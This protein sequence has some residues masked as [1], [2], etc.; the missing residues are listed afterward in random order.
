MPSMSWARDR[1][2]RTK[3]LASLGLLAVVATVVAA[4]GVSQIRALRAG[5]AAMNSATIQPLVALG[6]LQRDLQSWRARVTE[7]SSALAERRQEIREENLE[8]Q[9]KVE[10]RAADYLPTAADPAAVESLQQM[11]TQYAQLTEQE[12]FAAVDAGEAGQAVTVFQEKVRPLTSDLLDAYKTEADAQAAKAVTEAESAEAS[13]GS[14]IRWV[15]IVLVAGLLLA[16]A[17][18]FWVAGGI[19]R[20]LAR[21]REALCAMAR[22]D[23]TVEAKVEGRDELGQMA[24]ALAQAREGVR[25]LLVAVR[26]SATGME[27]SSRHLADAAVQVAASAAESSGQADVVANASSAVSSS[28]QTLASGSEQMGA[29]IREISENANQAAHVASQ[30]VGVADATNATVTALGESSRQIG[31]VVRVITSIAEQTKLLALNATIEAAR[32]GEAGKGFAVVANEVKE[33]ASETGRATGDIAARVEAI[34]AD[35]G[36]VV[37]AIAEIAGVIG[38]INDFTTTIASAVEEQTATTAEMSRNAVQ[39]ASGS[40]EI[41]GTIA[42]VAQSAHTTTATVAD[43]QDAASGLSRMSAELQGQLSRFTY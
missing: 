41:A 40:E 25:G 28:V 6:D 30:A 37:S 4:A 7:Y 9:Q 11:L 16:L 20:S 5:N 19:V 21:V 2:V 18:G 39:V 8:L 35:T 24:D 14:A 42:G 15:V 12:L 10:Q 27:R 36:S 32:A 43:V 29:S 26:D 22:G 34:Q 23:L 33:L 1:G 3:I 38:Q 17:L 31:E 13:A